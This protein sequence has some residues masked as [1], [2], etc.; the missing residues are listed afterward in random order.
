MKR[1]ALFIILVIIVLSS[2][3]R[4]VKKVSV[5]EFTNEKKFVLEY[6]D[7]NNKFTGIYDTERERLFFMPDCPKAKAFDVTWDACIKHGGEVD[8]YYTN[9]AINNNGTITTEELLI[10]YPTVEEA[11]YSFW[12]YVGVDITLEEMKAGKFC[13]IRY[14]DEVFEQNITKKILLTGFT[15]A[16]QKR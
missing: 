10:F 12:S 6:Y 16:Y 8:S 4:W 11:S 2:S 15:A 7:E 3:A 1:I 13:S 14:Y 5:D 9:V